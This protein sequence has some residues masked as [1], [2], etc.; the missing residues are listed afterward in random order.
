[1]M[2]AKGGRDRSS[3]AMLVHLSYTYLRED[4]VQS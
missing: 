1:M 4:E 3:V 2:R